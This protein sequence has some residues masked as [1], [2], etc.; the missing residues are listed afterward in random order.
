MAYGLRLTAFHAPSFFASREEAGGVEL[1]DVDARGTTSAD[2]DRRVLLTSLQAVY[3]AW[4]KPEQAQR[5]AA[6]LAANR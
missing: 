5:C 3:E 1:S 2:G 6:A 4:G